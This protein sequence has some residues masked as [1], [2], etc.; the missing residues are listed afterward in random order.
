MSTYL[1][2]VGGETWPF[3]KPP[4]PPLLQRPLLLIFVDGGGGEARVVKVEGTRLVAVAALRGEAALRGV[5]ARE[6]EEPPVE[7]AR[8]EAER[9]V[10]TRFGVGEEA[11]C[12]SFIIRGEG[13]RIEGVE[14]AARRRAPS[15]TRGAR[16][17]GR[18]VAPPAF[19]TYIR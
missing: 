15:E 17:F 11:R 12:V 7:R 3:A 18:A 9:G 6:P 8:G 2:S 14:A 19:V 13:G 4:P 16:P 1:L 5:V 10:G